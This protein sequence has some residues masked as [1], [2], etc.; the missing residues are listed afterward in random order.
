MDEKHF[1]DALILFLCVRMGVC[2]CGA[3][4]WVFAPL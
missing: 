4:T 3:V 1:I 2:V